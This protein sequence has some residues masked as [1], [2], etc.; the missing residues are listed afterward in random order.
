MRISCLKD[1]I[2]VNTRLKT[3]DGL[4]DIKPAF[5]HPARILVGIIALDLARCNI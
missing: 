3:S 1:N 5:F 2:L 4:K